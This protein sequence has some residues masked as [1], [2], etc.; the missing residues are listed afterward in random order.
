MNAVAV[1]GSRKFPRLEEVQSL[2]KAL[3]AGTIVV[4]GGAIGVDRTAERTADAFGLGVISLRPY[5]FESM[6]GREEFA[7]KAH[8][9]ALARDYAIEHEAN[10][11]QGMWF[12]TFRDAAFDRNGEIVRLAEKVY[13]FWDGKSTGTQN[14]IAHAKRLGKPYEVLT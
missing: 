1:V 2:V 8:W 4:S 10:R 11:R 13:A 9:T 12:R 3:P 7:Y 5:S 6:D 14:A